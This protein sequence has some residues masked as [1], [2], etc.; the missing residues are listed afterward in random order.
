V[1][2]YD[3]KRALL[4]GII[5]YAGTFPPASLPFEAAMQ[6]AANYRN[7]LRHPWLVSKFVLSLPLLKT[8]NPRVLVD[9][10]ADGSPWLFTALG[11]APA[12]DASEIDF[13]RLVEWDLR[14]IGRFNERG[15]YSSLRHAV[16][17][18]EV[19][20]PP[21]ALTHPKA[22]GEFLRPTLERFVGLT[23]QVLP[24]FELPMG[25]DW[26]GRIQGTVEALAEWHSESGEVSAPGVKIR[27][28]G[29]TPPSSEQLAEAIVAITSHALRFKATQGLHHALTRDGA[30]GFVNLF[31]ALTLA[32][33]LGQDNF[34]GDDVQA[35]LLSTKSED[36][37]FTADRFAWKKHELDLETI[38]A[39]RRRHAG[40]FGSCSIKEPDEFLTTELHSGE[41]S[42]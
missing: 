34:T 4:G 31:A 39:A 12:D 7:V 14:E 26:R 30:F 5:D 21:N 28:G 42:P 25:P 24:Y 38:E 35:C 15:T 13:A 40:C 29:Q 33:A 17:A 20:L 2:H 27:T 9:A 23:G 36:F 32:Q 11:S 16:V 3:S 37:R 1:R 19:R 18:Y 22:I 41:G 6:E 10:G 8:V